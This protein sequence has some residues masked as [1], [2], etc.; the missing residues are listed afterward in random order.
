MPINPQE[1]ED[2]GWTQAAR[3]K[4]RRPHPPTPMLSLN[5]LGPVKDWICSHPGCTETAYS[6]TKSA[7]ICFGG[8]PAR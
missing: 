8:L 2:S 3:A 1:A 4:G 7:P 5:S 6:V